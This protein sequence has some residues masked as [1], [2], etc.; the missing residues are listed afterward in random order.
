M[1]ARQP[2][3][4][5]RLGA[6]IR[7]R[8]KALNLTQAQLAERLAWSQE[9]VSTLETGKYGL[10][11]LPLLNHL[12]SALEFP[13]SIL[14]EAAGFG[15]YSIAHS[16]HTGTTAGSG[17]DE[18]GSDI[19]VPLQYTLQ[20][21]LGI[22]A[23]TLKDAM[24][25]A[26]DLLA[27]AM[28]AD[29]VDLFLHDPETD[30]LVALGT[31]NTPMGRQQIRVGLNRVPIANGGRQVEVFLTGREYYSGR[32]DQDP[33]MDRGVV[34]TLGVRSLCAVPL[35]V[36]GDIRGIIVAESAEP[37]RF[38]PVERDLF[39]A[40][41]RWI[42]MVA[43]RA[44]LHE[45]VTR[46]A[47]QEARRQVAEEMLETVAHDLQNQITPIKGEADLLLRRLRRGGREREM[48]Q[49]ARI[50]GSLQRLS[51]MVRDLLDA[52][53]LEGG[54]FSVVCQPV[55]LVDLIHDVVDAARAERP[56]IEVRTPDQL[57]VMAD[58]PR[59]TQALRNLVGNAIRHTPAG[60]PVVVSM[61]HRRSDDGMWAVIEVH[62]EG[63]G[64][65][66]ELLPRLFGRYGAGGDTVGHGL[67]LYLARGIATAHGGELTVDSEAG[68]GTTF[69]LT[70]PIRDHADG[71]SP[72]PASL[73]PI[74][75]GTPGEHP[76]L[77]E[78]RPE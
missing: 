25:E 68:K 78:A 65:S 67:G 71:S 69:T 10:P 46:Q 19:D 76:A 51:T 9:R 28:G 16:D 53:R 27:Q 47:L 15:T 38:S 18:A 20:R 64:I 22:Q 66:P 26:S 3:D 7:D 24:N 55:D 34:H 50:A 2:P 45:I 23:L 49:T 62:D 41:S 63:P 8:R 21:L 44:E 35:R 72:D 59:I 75:L 60:V 70:L 4:L 13:L 56:E 33:E 48:D 73:P 31:S 39:E 17:P 1:S 77:R 57:M 52:S 40:A 14:M 54:I 29:K 32:A 12:A 58:A 36:G 42:G 11:S 43:H 37:D 74:R 5:P 6:T 30:T 61:G